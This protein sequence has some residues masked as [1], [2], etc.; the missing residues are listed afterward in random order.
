MRRDRRVC[1]LTIAQFS[2]PKNVPNAEPVPAISI[3]TPLKR[4]QNQQAQSDRVALT[5]FCNLNGP[6]SNEAR[7]R[8]KVKK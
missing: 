3:R 1:F 5:H 4:L 2:R 7:S 6:L 8:M